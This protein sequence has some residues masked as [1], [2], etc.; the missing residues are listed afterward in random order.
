VSSGRLPASLSGVRRSRKRA[1][2]V[3]QRVA[4][5]VVGLHAIQRKVRSSWWSSCFVGRLAVGVSDFNRS[6]RARSMRLAADGEI[7][8]RHRVKVQRATVAERRRKSPSAADRRSDAIDGV[9]HA[10]PAS[11]LAVSPT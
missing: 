4:V 7:H 2:R 1:D 3:E 8:G 11:A 5:V 10:D 6:V 9:Y